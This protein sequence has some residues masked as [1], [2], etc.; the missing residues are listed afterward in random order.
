[1]RTSLLRYFAFSGRASRREF[2]TVFL[3]SLALGLVFIPAAA[4]WPQTI[5]SLWF[6]LPYVILSDWIG[7]SVAVR[8]MHDIGKSGRLLILALVP[9]TG[10]V[11][12]AWCFRR[13]GMPGENRYGASPAPSLT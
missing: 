6:G 13:A 7:L 12:L 8:R 5:G 2:T 11:F 4:R 9:I 1:M 3:T 10:I